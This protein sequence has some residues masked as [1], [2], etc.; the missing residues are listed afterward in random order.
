MHP[1]IEKLIEV[2]SRGKVVTDRQ[3][4]IIRRRA[5]SLGEDPDEAELVLDLTVNNNNRSTLN[6]AEEDEKRTGYVEKENKGNEDQV[7]LSQLTSNNKVQKEELKAKTLYR[8]M[9]GK[10]LCGVCS[11]IADK[12][13]V[14]TLAVRLFFFITYAVSLWVYI[15]MAI[16]L[17]KQ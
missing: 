12:M 3:R 15:I 9:D 4:E 10:L 13:N 8:K 11:G 16:T 17:P 1:D 2:A 5:I 7:V 6:S 14:S